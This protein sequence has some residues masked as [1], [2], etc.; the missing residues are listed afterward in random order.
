MIC[1]PRYTDVVP[2]YYLPMPHAEDTPQQRQSR[3]E[4]VCPRL[5]GES[6]NAYRASRDYYFMGE[7]R[8][9]RAL[10]NQYTY[11]EQAANESLTEKPPTQTFATLG[12]WSAKYG[13][14]GRAAAWDRELWRLST[15]AS[16]KTIG[17]GCIDL[18]KSYLKQPSKM[19]E[20][21]LVR[22][23]AI[24]DSGRTIL[25]EPAKWQLRDITA[26]ASESLKL[27]QAAV[28]P[29]TLEGLEVR[30]AKVLDLHIEPKRM[31]ELHALSV[32]AQA[33]MASHEQLSILAQG[34]EAVRSELAEYNASR[35]QAMEASGDE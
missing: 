10:L 26:F 12:G 20:F 29:A 23:Q 3:F 9:L 31:D 4:E 6:D 17:A 25:L 15:Y 33:G 16:G 21:P 8:S 1:R 18:E 28:G 7:G 13:W 27:I 14:V 34:I 5:P 11:L 35:E 32:L 19:L 2:P 24:D 22:S 30:Q